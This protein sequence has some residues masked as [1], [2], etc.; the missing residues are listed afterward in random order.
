MENPDDLIKEGIKISSP[1]MVFNQL[2]EAINDPE[3]SFMDIAEIINKDSSLSLRLLKIAN[4][5]FY[6][7]PTKIETITQAITVIG[8]N[9]LRDLVLATVV[10]DS[11]NGIPERLIN[12][13][14]FWRHSIA[15]GLAARVIATYRREINVD[16][17]YV[18]GILHDIGRLILYMEIP[19]QA[20][21][22]LELSKAEDKLLHDA[23][24]DVMGY[25]HAAVGGALLRAWKL[26]ENL[27][28][29]VAFHHA[30]SKATLYPAEV[31]IVHFADIVA[32]A[33]EKGSSGEYFLQ[34]LDAAAW[35]II[36]LPVSIISSITD[37]V[38]RQF[39]DAVQMFLP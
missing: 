22:A 32:S 1:L 35:D 29:S 9:Q 6:S 26:P 21:K 39:T 3:T 7:F 25:D 15:C 5:T 27:E 17:F 2:N 19:K 4:S 10:L 13:D 36:G 23:E 14:L 18:R 16:R 38:E 34:P 11:F 33:M 30:P 37:Q 28:E 12:M 31:A 8:T 24:Y 20:N